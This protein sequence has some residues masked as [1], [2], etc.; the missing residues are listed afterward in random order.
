MA[1]QQ[2]GTKGRGKHTAKL[3]S[4][5]APGRAEPGSK[6]RGQDAADRMSEQATIL[7]VKEPEQEMGR[8]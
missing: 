4:P 8:K 6:A 2:G 1:S 7:E 3:G 5:G